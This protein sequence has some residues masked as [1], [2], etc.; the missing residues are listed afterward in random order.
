MD[1][2]TRLRQARESRGLSREALL[3]AT[4]IPPAALAAIEANDIRHLPPYPYNKGFIEAYAREVDL[5]PHTTAHEFLDQFDPLPSPP[6]PEHPRVPAEVIIEGRPRRLAWLVLPIIAIV[7]FMLAGRGSNPDAARID[8]EGP[9]P[10]E[11]VAAV[12]DESPPVGPRADARPAGGSAEHAGAISV[13]LSTTGAAWVEARADGQR[14]LYELLDSG[15]ER[16]L[17]AERDMTMRIGDAGAVSLTFNGRQVGVLG[18]R[19]Q[20]RV[21]RITP[22]GV[23]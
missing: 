8:R 21:L 10:P 1:V 6:P 2:G 3:R 16:R 4:R 13:V 22:E 15:V 7:W 5:D 12:K 20:I 18:D 14:V 23:R 17:S 11:P 9:T 19:G